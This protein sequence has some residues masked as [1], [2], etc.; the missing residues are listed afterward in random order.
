MHEMNWRFEVS[1][2]RVWV[3]R[4]EGKGTRVG[5]AVSIRSYLRELSGVCRTSGIDCKMK[6]E[7]VWEGSKGCYERWTVAF[8]VGAGGRGGG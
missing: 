1:D 6:Y 4:C 3:G 8:S 2:Q 5:G 7:G